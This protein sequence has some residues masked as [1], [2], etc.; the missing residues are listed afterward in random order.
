MKLMEQVRG[1]IRYKQYSYRTEQAYC[2][3]IKRYI[4]FHN[5]RHP[6]EMGASDIE[7][8][9]TYLAVKRNVSVSTQNLALSSILFLYKEVLTADLPW[10]EN[11]TPAKRPK[12]LP[13]VLNRTE[14]THVLSAISNPLHHLILS[15]LY[16]SGMRMQ[17][18]LEL[19]IKDIDLSRCELI[20]RRGKGAKDRVTVIPQSLVKKIEEQIELSSR[21]FELDR[22]NSEPGVYLPDALERK[23][24]NAGCE[25]GWHW[26]LPSSKLSVC[27]RTGVRRRHHLHPKAIQRSMKNACRSVGITKPA[28]PHTLRHCFATHMLENG[29]DIRTVQELL[30]HSDVKTTMIYTHVLNKGGRGVTSPLDI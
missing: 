18:C 19:R 28:T 7:S 26:L 8:F 9:L 16:G 20:I 22:A 30:G 1:K 21:Y 24:P 23:Y 6:I 12:Q 10:L 14:V 15:L 13:V 17:E 11:F 3:W 25:F 29:Y 5:K 27:P 2:S 4:L